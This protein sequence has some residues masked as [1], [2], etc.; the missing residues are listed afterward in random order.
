METNDYELFA[1]RA[2]IDWIELEVRTAAP[3]TFMAMLER[4]GVPYVRALNAPKGKPGRPDTQFT[5]KLHDPRNWRAIEATLR[6]IEERFPFA[7][8]TRVVGIEV[9]LDAYAKGASQEHLADLAATFVTFLANPVG[10]NVR[11]PGQ[12]GTRCRT[13]G[14][15]MPDELRDLFLA[16]KQVVIEGRESPQAQRIYL[17]RKD[18]GNVQLPENE[19]R[20]RIEVTLQGEGLPHTDLEDWKCYDFTDLATF[21]KFR[22]LK[23]DLTPEQAVVAAANRQIGRKETRRR[24]EGGT[25]EFSKLT[26]AD[27]VLNG[28]G[29][30]A[31]RDLSRRMRR[32]RA[33]RVTSPGLHAPRVAGPNVPDHV[34]V[35]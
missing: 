13:R 14:A 26:L 1:F 17:K 24:K 35:W 30:E 2:V 3:T 7:A 34:Q 31:L 9:S 6:R 22:R 4:A 19:H 21:F 20:A 27:T 32:T 5:L 28:K 33:N 29:Y 15:P 23:D 10:S 11:V 16:D 12:K 25:R 8:A 18:H